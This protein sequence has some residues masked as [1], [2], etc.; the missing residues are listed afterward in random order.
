MNDG[1]FDSDAPL[2]SAYDRHHDAKT[3]LL[4]EQPTTTTTSNR[5]STQSI[6]AVSALQRRFGSTRVHFFDGRPL[7]R[8]APLE[9]QPLPY[10]QRFHYLLR[11]LE[12]L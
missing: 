4:A 5:F 1:V 11:Q 3:V 7:R 2:A 10:R 9:G 8:L 12:Q 6:A